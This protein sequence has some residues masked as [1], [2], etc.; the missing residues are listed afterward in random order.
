MSS[1][2]RYN[3]GKLPATAGS[4]PVYVDLS[5]SRM[6]GT[7]ATNSYS[8][9]M[10]NRTDWMY[11]KENIKAD[12]LLGARPRSAVYVKNRNKDRWMRPFNKN[13]S[14][15]SYR[16]EANK[17]AIRNRAR[18]LSRSLSI[19]SPYV[20]NSASVVANQ[21]TSMRI[22]ANGPTPMSSTSLSEMKMLKQAVPDSSFE[23]K[24][25]GTRDWRNTD[26]AP[27]GLV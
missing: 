5:S 8:R 10:P 25:E 20:T 11:S 23:A 3:E 15:P 2:K 19:P 16:V 7:A 18:V 9:Y 1:L 12:V 6:K 17:I 4:A 13:S 24:R 21:K 26:V 22:L 27:H 14:L